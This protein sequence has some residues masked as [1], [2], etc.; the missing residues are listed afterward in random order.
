MRAIV[1]GA[2]ALVAAV[3]ATASAAAQDVPQGAQTASSAGGVIFSGSVPSG[4][5]DVGGNLSSVS[6]FGIFGV[7]PTQPAVS[8][9][10]GRSGDADMSKPWVF[11]TELRY[12][13]PWGCVRFVNPDAITVSADGKHVAFDI[14]C[15]DGRG[16]DHYHVTLDSSDA[17]P[18]TLPQYSFAGGYR[19]GQPKFELAYT[20]REWG[21]AKVRVCGVG[22]DVHCFERPPTAHPGGW[23][24]S[25][26]ES[27]SVLEWQT[28]TAGGTL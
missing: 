12:Q 18:F 17:G 21:N 6:N 20:Q 2:L 16:Y 11:F 19:L 1:M 7:V 26:S 28:M 10:P 24:A 4:P 23:I 25:R 8:S 5:I 3:A 9:G 22:G 14:D 13:G 27:I 15:D